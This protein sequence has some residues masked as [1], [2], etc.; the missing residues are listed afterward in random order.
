MKPE[1]SMRLVRDVRDLELFDRDGRRCG[2]ADEFEFEGGPGG[3]LKITAL[4]VGPGAYRKRLPRWLYR[5]IRLV[6]GDR[7]TR[8]AWEEIEYITNVVHLKRSAHDY[9]LM[10]SEEKAR[11]WIAR[12]S[13]PS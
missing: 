12:W 3:D 10:R 6:A 8:V 2:I 1:A 7:V 5:L 11:T 4:L 13:P 9:G